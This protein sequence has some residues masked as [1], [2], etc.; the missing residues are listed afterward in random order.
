[1]KL[2]FLSTIST[3]A[4]TG[5]VTA[6]PIR[7]IPATPENTT[8]ADGTAF[9]SGEGIWKWLPDE[10]NG[11]ILETAGAP[12]ENASPLVLWADGLEPKADYDVFGYFW[13]PGF[14]EV[15][16][17]KEPHHWPAR[18]GLGMASLTTY[19]GKF[20]K[21][22]PWIISPGSQTGEFHGVSAVVEKEAPLG[23]DTL[24]TASG[25]T[26]LIRVRVGVARADAEGRL[27][28]FMDDFPD[29]I[30]CGRT[31]ID[32][33]AV[34]LAAEGSE[35]SAGAGVAKALHAALRAGDRLS[36]DRE[37][38]AGADVNALDGDGLSPLFHPAAFGDREMVKALLK[39]GADPNL[40][41]QSVLVLTAA[42]ST[43]DAAMVNLLLEAGA[44]VPAE[45]LE[46]P[47]WAPKVNYD[48]SHLHPAVAAIRTGSL[49]TLQLLLEERPDLDLESLGPEYDARPGKAGNN[50]ATSHFLVEETMSIEHD[51][52]AAFLID[53]GCALRGRRFGEGPGTSAASPHFVLLARSIAQGDALAETRKALFRRGVPAVRPEQ[54]DRHLNGGEFYGIAPWDG[55]SAAIGVGD[56][57]LTRELLPQAGD[58]HPRY[59]DL[60]LALARWS[61]EPAILR[62]IEERFP[63]AGSRISADRQEVQETQEEGALRLLLP[64]RKPAAARRVEND[65]QWT[66]AVI[67]APKAGGQGASLE[68]AASNEAG[69]T[70]VDRA[71]IETAL[72]EA[73]FADPWGKGEHSLAELGDRVSADLLVL[74]SLLESPGF[75]LL[76]F[77]AVDVATGLAVHR[78]HVG[79]AAFDPEK[80]VGPLLARVREAFLRTRSGGR[81][82][83]I[84]LLP[85][86]VSDEVANA[87]ALRGVFR[88]AIHSEVDATPGL[89]SVGMDE[90]RAISAEQTLAGRDS[91]WAAAFT[92]EGGVSALGDGRV[93]LTLRMR[94][95]G[96]EEHS[97]DAREEGTASELPA[98]AARAWRKLAA[99]DTFGEAD[100]PKVRPDPRQA[101]AEGAR[102]LRE[103]EWLLKSGLASEALPLFERAN[104]LGADPERLVS[105]HLRALAKGAI[106]RGSWRKTDSI[107]LSDMF[108]EHPLSLHYQKKLLDS[109][110]EARALLD[111]AAYYQSRHGQASLNWNHG[112]FWDVTRL[113]SFIRASIPKSLPPGVSE[114]AVRDFGTELDRFTAD[115]FRIRASMDRPTPAPDDFDHRPG[116][117]PVSAAMLR[118]NPEL[119]RGL[120]TMLFVCSTDSAGADGTNKGLFEEISDTYRIPAWYGK[121]RILAE[122][123]AAR[124]DEYRGTR[125]FLH[126]AE[127]AL[128]RS[129]GDARTSAARNL[130]EVQSRLGRR[131]HFHKPTW[132]QTAF[133]N[134]SLHRFGTADLLDRGY[135]KVPRHS[136]AMLA[137]FV[138]EPRGIRDWITRHG[139]EGEIRNIIR[140]EESP[141]QDAFRK[142]SER[143]RWKPYV[144]L[145]EK[146]AKVSDEPD[147]RNDLLEGAALQEMIDGIPLHAPLAA[148]WKRLFPEEK[149]ATDGPPKARLLAD[150][151]TADGSSTGLFEAPLI[152]S[153]RRLLWM[154]YHPF[155]RDSVTILRGPHNTHSS[156]KRQPWVVGV[157]CVSG[158][159]A[160]RANLAHAPGLNPGAAIRTTPLLTISSSGHGDGF[161]AQ[162]D[163]LVFTNAYWRGPEWGEAFTPEVGVLIDKDSGRLI[164]LDPPR[165][166]GKPLDPAANTGR[167]VGAV[168][169]GDEFF[170]LQQAGDP[171]ARYSR[172]DLVP[173]QLM[174]VG[175]SGEARPVTVHGRR[176]ELTPFD[177]PDRAPKAIY[178]DGAKLLV[179]HPWSN[180]GRF[181]PK[182]DSWD[183]DD[184]DI[185]AVHADARKLTTADLRKWI[186]PHHRVNGRGNEPEIVIEARKLL[187]GMLACHISGQTETRVRVELE[188]PDD[189]RNQLIFDGATAMVKTESGGMRSG[190][191]YK[192]FDE[193]N[194]SKHLHMVV[195][196]QT[197]NDLILGLQ[198][199]RLHK[200]YPGKR[201]GL[202]IPMLW[203]L[204]KD[205]FRAAA[206]ASVRRK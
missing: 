96:G 167:S 57:A 138:H 21:R 109:L 129:K 14:G 151:R 132:L 45:K 117:R 157:D 103:G 19:G 55:L 169:V 48:H 90:I 106:I 173:Y 188:I 63:N 114:S 126:E 166:I 141:S 116:R 142:H 184:R 40:P 108:T 20:S 201:G 49:E 62:M 84:T 41:G 187:P 154:L 93:S 144:E 121:H 204:P 170:Y 13:A 110:D 193:L 38:T 39:A 11:G 163:D 152:D 139:Y 153:R 115:Y 159:L 179:V 79:E 181:D 65:G 168:A 66:L 30:H 147:S 150:L 148:R 26:R 50:R 71:E 1:M 118:R 94:S 98:M 189:F 53:R 36:A 44:E 76:R 59:Q 130:R 27:P 25:D 78:E 99:A 43:G 206:S 28:V 4:I 80:S 176:P 72:G 33:V 23:K 124:M 9:S 178:R 35:P 196:N 8:F 202:F 194:A 182:D 22:I 6:E 155:E 75:K 105:F 174:R 200:W 177:L 74:V 52:L 67:A 15:K 68:V 29:S 127:L 85:F 56:R 171:R 73:G 2:I 12:G 195:L 107:R 61:G 77:E 97:L 3:A 60:L 32:G 162:T 69:C 198:T 191:E 101:A 128:I 136:E 199:G 46:P 104:L 111:A 158:E 5:I 137:S 87:S 192:S 175:A 123:A 172:P 165:P 7:F 149:P 140:L 81:P 161:L 112:D 143:N 186:F 31:R 16:D 205:E 51:E 34:R 146:A 18:F 135:P 131:D 164:G 42:A 183:M 70:V 122:A 17:G 88:A 180:T 156:V 58:V 100:A 64:R 83:A 89:L 91:M 133:G 203:A 185:R 24:S 160:I 47:P 134:G 86:S 119:L 113:L 190:G 125:R 37:M 197:E 102:L 145:M 95:L 92:L 54:V 10:G 120:V 82:K